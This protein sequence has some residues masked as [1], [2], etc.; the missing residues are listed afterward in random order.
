MSNKNA[1]VKK[2][3]LKNKKQKQRQRQGASG[4]YI[5]ANAGSLDTFYNRLAQRQRQGASEEYIAA[6]AVSLETLYNRLAALERRG[7]MTHEEALQGAEL[8]ANVKPG[9]VALRSGIFN[10]DGSG[11]Q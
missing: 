2:W 4:E 3:Q 11:W 9:Q 6:K 1:R 8:Y 5:A 10:L 7:E